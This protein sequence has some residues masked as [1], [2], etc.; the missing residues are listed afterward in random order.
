MAATFRQLEIVSALAQHR[1]FGRAAKALGISQPNL[2]RSLKQFEADLG[3]PIFDRQGVNPTLF[4][5]IILRYGEKALANNHQLEREV[6][7]A[8]GLEVGELRIAAGPYPADISG[9]RAVG[10][11][12]DKHPNVVVEINS[13]NWERV[14]ADV[15]DGAA[16]IGF[17]EVSGAAEHAQLQIQVVRTSQVFFFCA[18][19]HP[20][21]GRRRLAL[22]DLLE[23]PWAG[24]RIPE[25]MRA[26]LPAADKRFAVFGEDRIRLHPR[27]LVGSFSA[28]RQIVLSGRTLSVAIH[29]QIARELSEGV[30]VRLPF[31]APWLN[32]NYGFIIK[33]GR[34]LS[35]AAKSFMAIVRSIESEIPQ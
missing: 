22:D 5:E 33:R 24:P 30:F 21:A 34:T 9:E 16:D 17:A 3:V 8:K 32:I 15:L 25:R 26:A 27:A 10:I 29:S 1:H 23:Y 12:L 2:T 18:A 35:P 7:L 6:A 4:G 28:A 31:E 11:L 14:L 20:L 13:A 19:G